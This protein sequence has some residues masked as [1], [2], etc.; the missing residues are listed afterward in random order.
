MAGR[1]PSHGPFLVVGR[2]I[3][4]AGASS[5]PREVHG[6][7]GLHRAKPGGDEALGLAG[8]WLAIHVGVCVIEGAQ[9]GVPAQGGALDAHRKLGDPGQCHQIAQ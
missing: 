2:P 1:A 8:G 6:R 3:W 5:R 9:E 7:H 4:T